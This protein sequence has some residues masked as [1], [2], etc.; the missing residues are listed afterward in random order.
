MTFIHFKNFFKRTAERGKRKTRAVSEAWEGL[1]DSSFKCS[2]LRQHDLMCC[3]PAAS[4]VC[5]T[6]EEPA[7]STFPS[8][9]LSASS[10]NSVTDPPV[11]T[12][13][14][15]PAG[16]DYR[17][18]LAHHLSWPLSW[19]ALEDLTPM[20]SLESGAGTLTLG[21]KTHEGNAAGRLSHCPDV[22]CFFFFFFLIDHSYFL[23][24]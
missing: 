6:P 11:H 23:N 20:T 7:F 3:P 10:L 14:V 13:V 8:P 22:V 19:Q 5:S 12:Q 2:L 18:V 1:P 21:K 9:P 17:P 15:A 4:A 16:L 24:C